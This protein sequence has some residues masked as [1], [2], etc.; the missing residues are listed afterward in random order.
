MFSVILPT[1]NRWEQLQEAVKSVVEQT[2]PTWELLVIDDGSNDQTK[3]WKPSDNKIKVLHLNQNQGPGAARNYGIKQAT[4]DWI[5]FL[6]SDDQW[7]QNKLEHCKEFIENNDY[8]IFQSQDIWFKNN[9]RHYPKK[10]HLKQQGDIFKMATELC[11]V[12]M[13]SACMHKEVLSKIG[14][15][16]EHYPVCEDYDFWLRVAT[17]YYFG[18]IDKELIILNSGHTD[19]VSKRNYIFDEWRLKSLINVAKNYNLSDTQKFLTKKRICEIYQILKK[20]YTKYNKDQAILEL[21]DNI[22]FLKEKKT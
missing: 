8:K 4:N 2:L 3:H 5:C 7:L 11:P 20:G 22:S 14:W 18:L 1:Y 17:Q 16:N 9:Q 13:S 6:D 12:S 10:K 21:E 19:Q 15:F